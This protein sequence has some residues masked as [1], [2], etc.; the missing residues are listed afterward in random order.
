MAALPPSSGSPYQLLL[1]AGGGGAASAP[2]EQAV[3]NALGVIGQLTQSETVL[4][5]LEGRVTK[6]APAEAAPPQSPEKVE[7]LAA[8]R[9][10]RLELRD[11]SPEFRNDRDIVLAAVTQDGHALQYASEA[12]QNDRKIVLAAVTQDGHV[13]RSVGEALRNDRD[14][15]LAAVKQYGWALQYAGEALRNE[16]DIV[17]VAVTQNGYALKYAGYEFQN[18]REIVLAA[19]KHGDA[20]EFVGE[21]LRNE[22]DI[23]LAAVTYSGRQ[24]FSSPEFR[25]ERDIVRVAVTQNGEALEF[26]GEALRNDHDIVLAAVI[27]N[28]NA[29]EFASETLRNDRGIVL[30][31]VTQK[32]YALKGASLELQNDPGFLLACAEENGLVLEFIPAPLRTLE[33]C[34][35]ALTQNAEAI[36][37]VPRAWIEQ[38]CSQMDNP[39]YFPL[40]P[41]EEQTVERANRAVAHNSLF[42]GCI[43]AN[44]VDDDILIAALRRKPEAIKFVHSDFLKPSHVASLVYDYSSSAPNNALTDPNEARKSSLKKLADL[45][46]KGQ[47]GDSDIIYLLAQY[48]NDDREF[49]IFAIAKYGVE[50]TKASERLRRDPTVISD[51]MDMNPEAR[52]FIPDLLASGLSEID[53]ELFQQK[54]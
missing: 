49:M 34:A 28:V 22:R 54:R 21:A 5:S 29:L 52:S 30:A 45:A 51:I 37:H 43:N 15:V 13:F 10:N 50:F 2:R 25:N 18:D 4:R 44:V 40:L 31:A 47:I 8:V 7:I 26:A 23:V 17:R 46:I 24:L 20:L 3:P 48:F 33:V 6:A 32:G 53:P 14:I 1:Q 35:A 39:S 27:Q 9:Q 16:R 12:L 41:K 42:L 38:A 19:V 11:V 36:R